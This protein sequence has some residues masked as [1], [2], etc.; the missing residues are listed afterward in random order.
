M[1]TL[2]VNICLREAMQL[3]LCVQP[4]LK[5]VCERALCIFSDVFFVRFPDAT[6]CSTCIL[7]LSRMVLSF[8]RM[9]YVYFPDGTLADGLSVVLFCHLWI[10]FFFLR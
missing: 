6:F 5:S 10:F 7:S 9:V 3:H 4:L 2:T 8:F 1:A